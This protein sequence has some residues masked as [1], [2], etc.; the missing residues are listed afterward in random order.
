MFDSADIRIQNA[1]PEISG[2]S[3]NHSLAFGIYLSGSVD[4]NPDSLIQNNVFY[5]DSLAPI[6]RP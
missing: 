2:D 1:R 5:E 6:R 4:P 3:I